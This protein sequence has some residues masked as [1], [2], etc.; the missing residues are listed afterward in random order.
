MDLPLIYLG[1]GGRKMPVSN[2]GRLRQQV[3]VLQQQF[4][5]GGRDLP[6]ADVLTADIVSQ[7]LIAAKV[8]WK[9]RVYSPLVT[10]SIFVGQVLSADH[11][12]RLAVA[13]FNA[14]RLARGKSRCSPETGAYCQAR[15]RLP[16]L[17]FSTVA[18]LVGMKLSDQ[19]TNDWLWKG[20]RVFLV[21]GSTISMP[22]TPANQQAY[23]QHSQK[24]GRGFPMARIVA[25]FSLS[26]GVIVNLGI[27]RYSGKGQGELSL[28]HRLLD[29]FRP[30]DVV[31]AD[32]LY[33]NWPT[34][35]NLQ[36]RGV[37]AVAQLQIMRTA[38]FRKG[39]RL[40]EGDP[41]VKWQKPNSIRSLKWSVYRSLPESITVRECRVIIK[42]VGFR[43][44]A[45]VV[46]T[47]LLDVDQFSKDDLAALY[48]QRWNAELDLRSIKTTMQMEILRCKTPELVRKEIWTHVL[49]YN[50]IRTMMAQAAV[51]H[52]IPP[53]EISFKATIQTLEAYQAVIIYSASRKRQLRD[54]IGRRILDDIAANKVGDRTERIEPRQVTRRPKRYQWMMVSRQEAKRQVLKGLK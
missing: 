47:T 6:F 36:K 22:D 1:Q 29:F 20:H 45:V 5:Q 43:S 30:G 51:I 26:C 12:C 17:F 18:K 28:F 16:E 31:L 38:D 7:A 44:K 3:G 23:P 46:V 4:L 54:A 39:Q 2:H 8:V 40:G 35:L 32:R 24:P 14:Y 48:L 11:S 13:R 21:D 25:I 9:E 41:I 49:A 37:H 10:L 27:C 34:L 53:R 42:R 33:G 50:L 52:D 15:R 19:S